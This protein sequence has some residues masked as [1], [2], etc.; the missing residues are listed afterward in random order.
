[1]ANQPKKYKKFVATAATATLVASAIVP[2]ASAS[3]SD[4]SGLNAETQAAIQALVDAGVINGSLDK[5][6]PNQEITRGQVVKLLGKWAEAQGAT[7]PADWNTVQRFDDLPVDAADQELVK[8]AAL[9]KDAGIFLGSNG[10]L[11]AGGKITRQ[12]MALVVNRAYGVLF[13]TTLVELAADIEDVTVADLSSVST[14]AQPAVQALADL[15]ITVLPGGN[16]NPASNVTRAQFALFVA[17]AASTEAPAQAEVAS[18]ASVNSTTLEVTLKTATTG[19]TAD[20]FKITVNGTAVTPTSVT[21]DATGAK[22][23]I[24]HADLNNTKGSV[25]VNGVTANFDYTALKVESVSAINLKEIKVTFNQAVDKTTAEDVAN[26][27]ISN[28]VPASGT[29]AIGGAGTIVLS[30]DAKSVTIYL[31]TAAAQ[32]DTL[33]LTVQNVKSADKAKTITKTTNAVKFLDTV[34]PTVSDIQV[35]GKNQVE[36]TLSESLATAP[37]IKVIANGVTYTATAVQNSNNTKAV[38]TLSSNLPTGTVQVEV[39]GGTD[40]AGY[41]IEKVTKDVT[42]ST[43]ADAPTAQITEVKDSEVTIKFNRPIKATTFDGNVNAY[44]RH[45]YNVT[46]ANEVLGNAVGVTN[47]SGDNQ[48]FVVTFGTPIPPGASTIYVGLVNSTGTAIEDNFGNKFANTSYAINLTADVTKPVVNTVEL[49]DADTIKVVFSEK[50]DDTTGTNGAKNTA[51]YVLKDKDGN[52]IAITN[53]TDGTSPADKTTFE[54]N[55]ATN[56]I[57][58][59]NYTLEIKNIKDTAVA[60]NTLDTVTKSLTVADK[61]APTVNTTGEVISATKVRIKFSEAMDTT[62]ITDLNNYGVDS[63]AKITAAADNKSVI[64]DFADVTPA[65]NYISGPATINVGRVKDVAGNLTS[66]F[67]TTVNFSGSVSTIGIKEAQVTALDKLVIVVE[68]TLT[69]SA[70]ATLAVS[71]DGGTTYALAN[72]VSSQAVDGKTNVTVTLPTPIA[73]TDTEL[74]TDIKV[75]TGTVL[76][77]VLTPAASTTIKNAQGLFLDVAATTAKDKVAPTV[78]S[79]TTG[80]S[81]ADGK[82]DQLT[83]Q[84]SE[85]LYADSVQA[86]DF[87]VEGYTVKGVKALNAAAGTVTLELQEGIFDTAATPKVQVVGS[88]SDVLGNATTAETSAVTS[89]DGAAPVVVSAQITAAGSTVGFGNDV[90]DQLTLTFSEAVNTNFTSAIAPTTAELNAIFAGNIFAGTGTFTATDLSTTAGTSLVI[91]LATGSLTSAI[92]VDSNLTTVA[93]P[94]AN[95]IEDAVDTTIAGSQT[96]VTVK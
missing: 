80:D 58:G 13:G 71:I 37:T 69:I 53:V 25:A 19:L 66:A 87:T 46:G 27:T 52:Q 18:V 89:I 22:Y 28:K 2:V 93:T 49:K 60:K 96:A 12:Q 38:V 56:A 10:K 94:T 6:N 54:L 11:N 85:A 74:P 92:L 72:V 45:T 21:A 26:Y 70:G 1:M 41:A 7:V 95:D 9:V 43:P 59:G 82:I 31:G 23:T 90:A 67:S 29:A 24:V 55:T 40:Y 30:A 77:G 79:R 81:D 88:V 65:V 84:F 68:D 39:S 86:T 44:I 47:P 15:G 5:F 35:I 64:I 61:V 62:S 48:T 91:T 14:E 32:Q 57:T 83:V 16:F 3:F 34:L 76:G 73:A 20:N 42:V 50:V 78:V 17:R 4:V 36:V 75:A 51:N 33:D 63:K 8:Y